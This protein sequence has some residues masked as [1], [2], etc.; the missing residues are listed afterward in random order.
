[1]QLGY[2]VE[3]SFLFPPDYPYTSGT[4]RIL[5]ENFAE[6]YREVCSRIGITRGDVVVDIGSN[7][8]TL[9][10]NF[11]KDGHRVV[12]VEPT[13]TAMLAQARGIPTLTTFFDRDAVETIRR[14]HGVP[15]VVTATNVFAHIHNVHQVVNNIEEL[16]GEHGVF[17][18]ES[19]YLRDL[20]ETLQYDTIYHEHLRYYA[21]TSLKYL[22]ESHGLRVFYAK[23]ISTHGGS[24]RVYATKSD[25]YPVDPSVDRLLEEEVSAGLTSETWIED[26]RERVVRSKVELYELLARLKRERAQVYG[27]GAP[28]RAST[29]INYV[30][31]DEGILPC[32]L[33]VQGSKKLNKYIPGTKIPVLEESRLYRD[34]PPF[35]LLLS[36]HI[37]SELCVN[38]KRRGYQGDFVVPLQ[39][40]HVIRNA[41]V[42]VD[43]SQRV[44]SGVPRS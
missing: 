13:L 8:G 6:L 5:R 25:A 41:Q 37:A 23:R 14:E 34:Q 18:S 21:L 36:W 28:S 7:D 2:A 15:K 33:E 44:G 16:I 42:E 12:G 19:H 32:V 35:T 9:L 4:T 1:V 39:S 30:G 24:I 26:F 29:L 22:L 3:P 17:I 38:L 11:A 10:S 31:L 27:I 43:L 40:P 20:V